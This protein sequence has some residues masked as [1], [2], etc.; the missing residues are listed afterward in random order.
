MKMPQIIDPAMFAACGINC[1]VC[2]KR[3]AAGKQS[4]QCPGC[5]GD[6]PGK[7]E[8]CRQCALRQCARE[9]GLEYCFECLDGPCPRLKRLEKS[10]VQRYGVSLLENGEKV[11]LLGLAEFLAEER[12]RWR[13]PRCS[14]VISMHDRICG[15]CRTQF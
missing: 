4:R 2:Y 5:C 12:D 3:A 8:R 6:G 15:E 11:K 7:T 13:C 10:Y 14:G 9:R 1:L